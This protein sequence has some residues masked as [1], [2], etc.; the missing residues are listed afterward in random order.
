MKML[1]ITKTLAIQSIVL[2]IYYYLFIMM[3]LVT[4]SSAMAPPP[5]APLST[6]YHRGDNTNSNTNR[7]KQDNSNRHR[8]L[9][10]DFD[11]TCT[12]HDTTAL[13][14]QLASKFAG[15]DESARASRMAAFAVLQQEYMNNYAIANERIFQQCSDNEDEQQQLLTLDQAL[16][17]LEKVSTDVTFKISESKCLAGV[18]RQSCHVAELMEGHCEINSS[19]ALH[20]ECVPTIARAHLAGWKLGV[21]SINWCPPL[22]DAALLRP[23]RSHLKEISGSNNGGNDSD[24]SVVQAEIWSNNVNA[25]GVVTLDGACVHIYID[26]L[27]FSLQE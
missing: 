3:C 26:P 23:V 10:L 6:P 18:P 20:K 7:I 5:S 24:S 2:L 21:L 9:V 25:E 13:L 11:G 1:S 19:L 22:I 16:D 8:W 17:A 27:Y 15:D 4:V 12:Q 14:P